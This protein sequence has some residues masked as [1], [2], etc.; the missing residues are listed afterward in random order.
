[1]G[2]LERGIIMKKETLDQ[3]KELYGD[4]ACHALEK[5]YDRFG[6]QKT[7][8]VRKGTKEIPEGKYLHLDWME[9]VF[10]PA[11]VKKIGKNAFTE[12]P[13]HPVFIVYGGTVNQWEQIDLDDSIKAI[14]CVNCLD[15]T[16]MYHL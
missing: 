10:V 9:A 4:K 14:P 16:K 7:F 8:F 13:G 6:F 5:M 2:K 3:A 11:S 15:G 1:M 12:K